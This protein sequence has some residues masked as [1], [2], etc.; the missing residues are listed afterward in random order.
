MHFVVRSTDILIPSVWMCLKWQSMEYIVVS[1]VL[2]V[3][4]EDI[5]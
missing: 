1:H 2:G 5:L 4:L 3:P